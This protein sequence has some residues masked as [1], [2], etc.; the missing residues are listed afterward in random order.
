[1]CAQFVGEPLMYNKINYYLKRTI[2]SIYFLFLMYLN[3]I[4][5]HA[6]LNMWY[7]RRHRSKKTVFKES[8][9]LIL[10]IS[11]F[12]MLYWIL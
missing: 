2:L 9:K 6:G 7:R 3:F 8:L 1:M 12:F 10:A 11:P 4:I 5:F